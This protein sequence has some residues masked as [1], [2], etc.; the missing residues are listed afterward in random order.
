MKRKMMQLLMVSACC[1]TFVLALSVSQRLSAQV[2]YGAVAGTVQDSTGAVIAGADVKFTN[3]G[4]GQVMMLKTDAE[5]HYLRADF[6]QGQYSLT[7][8]FTGFKPYT[9][10]GIQMSV[11]TSLREDV[12]LEIGNPGESVIVSAQ[13]LQLQ[14][15][16]ADLHTELSSADLTDLP[17]GHY[18]NFQSLINLVPGATPGSLVNSLQTSPERSIA[19]NVNGVN[20][21][22]N[23]TRID[24]LQSIYLWLT[25]HAAYIPPVETI[26][27]VNISTNSF[28]AESGMAGGA[29]TNIISKSGTN[30]IHGSAFA[31]NSNSETAA[32]NFFNRGKQA[33]T[34]INIDGATL[35]GPIKKD[36]IFGFVGW[37]GTRERQ[38]TTAVMTVPTADQRTGNFSAYSTTLYDPAT[39]NADGTARSRLSSNGVNNVIPTSR[40]NPI[41]QKIQSLIPLPN[42]AGT[43]NNYTNSASQ[44]LTRDNYD[45]KV[46]FNLSQNT[47]LWTKYSLMRATTGCP[48][49]LGDAGGVP[50]C[51]GNI[52]VSDG[53]TQ[54]ADIGFTKVITPNIS[55]DG[56]V[57]YVRLGNNVYG[58]GYGVS[59]PLT[60]LGIPGT[61]G[62]N[63]SLINSGAPLFTISNG[64]SQLGS[65]TET[66]PYLYHQDSY[67]IAQNLSWSRGKHYFR[68]GFEGIRHHMNFYQPDGGGGGGPQGQFLFSGGVTSLNGGTASI[69]QYNSYAAFLLGLPQ[70][71]KETLQ[72]ANFTTYNYEWAGYA[73]DRWQIS[74][75]LMLSIGLRYELYPMMTRSGRGGIEQYNPSTN[76]VALGGNGGNPKGVGISTNHKMFVPRIGLAYNLNSKT[77][78][79]TGFGISIDPLP[80]ARPLRGFYPLTVSST[81]TPA[82]TY[83]P[84]NSLATG[85]PAIPAPDQ[86]QAYLPLPLTAQTRYIDGNAIKRGYV[87]SWNLV[88]ERELPWQLFATVAYV[89]TQTIHSFVDIDVNAGVPGLGTAGQALNQPNTPTAGRTAVTWSWNGRFNANY[90]GL[91]ISMEKRAS[92][93][94]TIKGAYTYSKAMNFT[95]NDG[96]AQLLFNTPSQIPKNYARAGYDVPHNL[97]LA[98][99]YQLPFGHGKRFATSGLSS[100]L[101]GGWQMNGIFSAVSGRPFTVTADASTL[102]APGNTQTADL[103][104]PIRRSGGSGPGELFYDPSSFAVPTGAPRFGTAGRN[105]LRSQRLVNLDTGL[106]KTIPIHERLT[107][108]FKAEAF[109]ISNTPHFAA[110]NSNRSSTA[111]MTTS[112]AAQDQ[113]N[114][115]FGLSANW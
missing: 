108:T 112:S 8:S 64:Y 38:G 23:G 71:E 22:N 33:Y 17:V 103:V 53:V 51:S 85:I 102:N 42:S 101:L 98:S 79:R 14:A 20:S 91:Q 16:K 114:L 104:G 48:A 73:Q 82:N 105:I 86:T 62:G 92:K 1:L 34:N 83:M 6:Q 28:D 19:A 80:L 47:N 24:G 36:K 110:P 87:E 115:R 5:G 54:V 31:M 88:I 75:Q 40:L 29:V 109:N 41:A 32:K 95:D 55:W 50:L 77:V 69:N 107:M 7:I 12:T 21:N 45:V 113:R 56:T 66:R 70:T 93:D 63:N 43:V 78:I 106:F 61:N 74:P 39:G 89:G 10:T 49:G 94:L 27:A 57:G 35:G 81:F 76:L 11:G 72:F 15:D 67:A 46:N 84:Y 18:R 60:Q 65:D 3:V 100:F 96:W 52:G 9:K 2:L 90:N 58:L 30:A 4:T 13:E 97:Q 25:D 99:T 26:Q 59:I 111:F 68:F 44:S 37:E